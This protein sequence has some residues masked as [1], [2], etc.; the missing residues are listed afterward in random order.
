MP[1]N[2]STKKYD[3]IRLTFPTF[4]VRSKFNAA[5]ALRSLGANAV[6]SLGAELDKINAAGP[7]QAGNIHHEAIVEVTNAGT[8]SAG[9]N[10]IEV[11]IADVEPPTTINIL[12]DRPFIFIIQ[13]TVNKIPVMVGRIKNPN[14]KL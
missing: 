10:T 11:R 5:H 4:K 13:D 6:F 14:H 7:I 12:L 9:G 3:E 1:K 2:E 8:D